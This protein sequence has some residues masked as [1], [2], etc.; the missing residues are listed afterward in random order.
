MATRQSVENLIERTNSYIAEAEQQ[1]NITNRNGYE[2]D[3]AYSQAQRMLSE[4]EL[5]IEKM[6]V[7]ANPQQRDQLHRL[8]LKASQCLNDMI[9]D[10]NDLA[11]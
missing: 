11:D 5:E 10:Q 2:V 6:M 7:S 4:I 3:A 8:H 9:L 1:L